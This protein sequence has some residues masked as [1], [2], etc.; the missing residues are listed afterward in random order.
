M[1]IIV[2]IIAQNVNGYDGRRIEVHMGQNYQGG[3]AIIH[4]PIFE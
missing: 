3:A 2:L 4:S 1:I